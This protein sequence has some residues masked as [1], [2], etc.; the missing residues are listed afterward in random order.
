MF[1]GMYNVPSGG[2]GSRSCNNGTWGT[3]Y[4]LSQN[5]FEGTFGNNVTSRIHF[6]Q[7][8]MPTALWAHWKDLKLLEIKLD[9]K[10]KWCQRI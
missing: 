4:G 10:S 8:Y 3:A 9:E 6:P 1:G 5:G 2:T 7:R